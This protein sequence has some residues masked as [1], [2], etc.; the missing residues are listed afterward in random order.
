MTITFYSSTCGLFCM[1]SQPL[2]L[3]LRSTIALFVIIDPIGNI[4]I[5]MSLTQNMGRDERRQIVKVASVTGFTLLAV[6]ALFGVQFLAFF[7][8]S[9]NSFRIAGGIL[10]LLISLRILIEGGWRAEVHAGESGAVPLGF[11]LL[12]GPGAITTTMVTIQTS[13]LLVTLVAVVT[14]S[15]M[16]VICLALAEEIYRLLG[17]VGSNVVARVMAVFI[18]AIAV[19]FI[20]EGVSQYLASLTS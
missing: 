7:N 12:V 11:P 4:P 8:I 9:M 10:L 2:E 18:A 15:V 14:V 3:I 19:E 20:M 6:F 5:F 16:T 17:R 1:P 13:G